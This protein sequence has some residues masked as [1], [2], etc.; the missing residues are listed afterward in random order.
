MR[1]WLRP[2]RGYGKREHFAL[3]RVC[4]MD[5]FHDRQAGRRFTVVD[6]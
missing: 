5:R 2:D 3:E 1:E 6:L 4:G